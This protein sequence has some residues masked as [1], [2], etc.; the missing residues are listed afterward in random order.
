MTVPLHTHRTAHL[1]RASASGTIA[2]PALGRQ[3]LRGAGQVLEVD[4][5]MSQRKNKSNPDFDFADF[6]RRESPHLLG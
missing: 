3:V 4:E 1:R 2:S 6:L 5:G